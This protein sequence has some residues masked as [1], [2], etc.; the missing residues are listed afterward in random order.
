[1]RKAGLW[2]VA[3]CVGFTVL[4]AVSRAV[5]LL[6]GSITGPLAVAY[7]FTL[8]LV[9]SFTTAWVVTWLESISRPSGRSR[10]GSRAH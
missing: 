2:F 4:L 1:M 6:F 8:P 9:F 10:F 5:D 7:L 3:A